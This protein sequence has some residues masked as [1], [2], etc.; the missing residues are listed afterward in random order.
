MM[1]AITIFYEHPTWF[2][3]LFA[4][5]DR[6]GIPYLGVQPEEYVFDPT[7][8]RA[9]D[10]STSLFVNRMSPSAGLR[11]HGGAVLYTLHWL[12]HLERAGVSTFNG[13]QAYQY[14]VS[15]ALQLSLLSHLGLPVPR[16]RAVGAT[17]G[18]LGAAQ[19]L[20]FPLVV[21]PNVGG[22]GVG[23][24]RFDTRDELA[25][26]VERYAL[27]AGIDGTL[28]LQE[29]HHPQGQS[30]VRVETLE[31]RYLYAIR[32]HI[33]ESAGFNLCPADLCQSAD[34][35]ERDTKE[36]GAASSVGDARA[37]RFDPPAEVIAQVEQ[38]ARAA[39]LDAGGVEYLESARD[40]VRYFYDI[41]ALSNFVADPMRVLGFDPTPWLADVLVRRA[42][43]KAA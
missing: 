2:Q 35:S 21:K 16:T 12:S 31:G 23:V 10:C 43:R 32:V 6:R 28:L 7:H 34:G 42:N 13:Y 33:D 5:L 25:Y 9:V 29:Y 26:Q 14:E 24:V 3:P 37:E 15:K 40:G 38:I 39:Q 4:E 36:G 41:N 8:T 18:L 1:P 30:I 17:S 27:E 19:Q 22:S 20:T 11:G